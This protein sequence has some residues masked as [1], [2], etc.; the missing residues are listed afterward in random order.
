MPSSCAKSVTG[1]AHRGNALIP[2]SINTSQPGDISPAKWNTE[3]QRQTGLW[4]RDVEAVSVF[5]RDWR[6]NERKQKT[7]ARSAGAADFSSLRAIG[8]SVFFIL[9]SSDE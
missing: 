5:D 8:R 9:H 3:N 4:D 2:L 7:T 1:N 6:R